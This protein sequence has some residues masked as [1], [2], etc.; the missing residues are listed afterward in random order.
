MAMRIGGSEAS[1][2]GLGGGAHPILLYE[3]AAVG[4]QKTQVAVSVAEIQAGCRLW[5]V[6]ATIHGG[7]SSFHIGT[8]EPVEQLQTL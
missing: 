1:P 7:P 3:L 6:F 4:V 5:S 8:L 2:E